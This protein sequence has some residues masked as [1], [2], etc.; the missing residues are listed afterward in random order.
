MRRKPELWILGGLLV[1]AMAFVLWYVAGRRAQLHATP[2]ATLARP[3]QPTPAPAPSAPA[4]NPT[5]AP[6]PAAPAVVA[7]VLPATATPAKA[8][9][10]TP[11]EPVDLTQHDHQTVDFSGGKPVVKNT[12]ADKAAIDAALKD[13]ESAEKDVTF[14]SPKKKPPGK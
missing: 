14:E 3:S 4:P 7:D 10:P 2:P 6:A 11:A 9:A 8:A 13:I 1:A 5:P 12:A